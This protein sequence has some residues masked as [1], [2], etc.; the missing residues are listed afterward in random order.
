VVHAGS[1]E[2]VSRFRQNRACKHKRR[3]VRIKTKEEERRKS[4]IVGVEG[5]D[6]AIGRTLERSLCQ[7]GHNRVRFAEVGW[8]AALAVAEGNRVE[9]IHAWV[10]MC[11]QLKLNL[12][13][14]PIHFH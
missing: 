7:S 3:N 4:T 2:P 9:L 11:N 14:N 6:R 1:L 8:A 13:H 5:K 10:V 12:G